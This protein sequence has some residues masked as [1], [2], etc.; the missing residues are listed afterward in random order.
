MMNCFEGS[1]SIKLRRY[2]KRHT[3]FSPTDA[4]FRFIISFA[5]GDLEGEY[6]AEQRS[7]TFSLMRAGRAKGTSC[8]HA[9]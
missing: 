9:I 2:M 1:V 7:T 4:Q 3:A 6:Q 5:F 8:S